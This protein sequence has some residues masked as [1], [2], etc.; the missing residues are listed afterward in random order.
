M[1][2]SQPR[3]PRLLLGLV[4]TLLLCTFFAPAPAFASVSGAIFTTDS[5]GTQVNGNIYSS[6]ADVYLN[7][8]PQNKQDPGLV[9]D[10]TYYFQV[11]D[12][13][14]A[15]LLSLDDIS[16][17]QVVVSGGRITGVPTTAPLAACVDGYHNLGTF[18][19]ANGEQ[20]V[21]LCNPNAS[22]CPT[23]FADTP[24]PG[25]VYKVWLTPVANYNNCSSAS[26]VTFGF[27]DSDSKTDTFKIKKPNAAYVTVCKFNDLN[28][29]GVQDSGEPLIPFWP[30]TATGVDTMSGPIGTVQAQTDATGCVS[31][32]VS[33]FTTAG[34]VVTMT[35][36]FLAG[37]WQ[38]TAPAVGSYSVPD[39][40][41]PADN[42][43]VTVAITTN[44]PGQPTNFETLTLTAGDNVAAPN[45]G[46]TCLDSTCGGNTIELTVTKD[47]NPM[48]TRT[49]AWGIT[50]SV[51]T[52]TVYSA[53]GGASGPANYTVS[54]THDSGTDSGWQV[55]GTINVSNPSLVDITGVTITDA[56]DN[57][58]TCSVNGGSAITVSAGMMAKIPYICTYSSL[59]VSGTNTATAAWNSGNSSAIGTASIN[60]AGAPF[61]A[62]DGSVTVTD[63]YGGTLGTVSYTDPSPTTYTYPHTF[64][65][66]AGTCTSHTNTATFT[67]NTTG[68][69]GTDSKTVA[70]CQGADLTVSKTATAT[71]NSKISKAVD[72]TRINTS[73]GSSATF[74]YT[75]TVTTS[76]WAVGGTIT[77]T[78]PND[79][80]DVSV[81]LADALSDTGG[82][83]SI[84]GGNTQTVLRSSSI[85]PTYSCNFAAVPGSSSGTNTATASWDST[86]A[87]TPDSSAQGTASFTFSA[88]TVTDSYKGTLGTVT[89]PPGSG[90]FNYSRTITAPAG[91]C[92]TYNNTASIQGGSSSGNV[93]VTVC[94]GVDL[95][96][97]KTATATYTPSITKTV[98]K[99]EI[100]TS[101]GSSAIFNY[102]VKVTTSGWT[103]SGNISVM[104]P[105]DWESITA[106]VADTLSDSG[107]ACAVNGGS[108]TVT[109]A[110]G[111]TASVPYT[112]S[113]AAVPGA[114]SGTNTATASWNSAAAFT[115]DASAQG[116]AGYTFSSFTVTDTYAGALGT[117]SIPPGSGT[118]AYSRTITAPTA[119]CQTYPNTASTSTGQSASQSVKVCG[120]SPLT[121]AKTAAATFASAIAKSV[122]KT[123]VQQ[124]GGNITFNY[125]VT[126]TESGWK[127][128]GN[129]MVTNPNNWESITAAVT[130]ALTD[131]GGV[132]SVIGGSGVAVAASSTATLPYS[133]SFA[134]RPTLTS[135]TNT[136]TATWNA[137]AAHTVANS[138][139]GTAGYAFNS[140]TITDNVQDS[141]NPTGCNATLGT[142]SVTTTTPN[143][144]PGCGVTSL[145][146][147]SWGAF[148]YSVADA[149]ASP[150]SCASYN[151]TA[152]ITGGSSSNQVTVTV[153]NTNTGALTMG[154]WKNSNGQSIITNHCGSTT[155]STSLWAYLSGFNP[156]KDDT[157]A[158][159][160]TCVK[161]A[162]YVSGIISGATCTS[163]TNTCNSML[164]A[165]ML[166]T[167]LDVYFSTPGLGGNQIGGYNGLG[168]K[169]PALGGVAIDLSHICSMIDSSSGSTCTGTY[170][171][172]RPEFGI[173]PPNLGTYVSNMLSYSDFLS[174]VNGSPV[175]SANTGAT[176]Y[177][178]VKGKQVIAKDAFD[179]INNQ[180][181][182]IAPSGITTPSF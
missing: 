112:C 10:G 150:G 91:T 63:T 32:S 28:G 154:F 37:S 141:A 102:T 40:V 86:A 152:Q 180:I 33:D 55:T 75:V 130:D 126:V 158:A 173:A 133:C 49:F 168:S 42:G 74:N 22:K 53:G 69:T 54:V 83:C 97:S 178:Q 132:C 99:T 16:C 56:V 82:A 100:D 71:Y 95:K 167:A 166:A 104:N 96:V 116:T 153:C 139:M 169:Q 62:V 137:T 39:G 114:S 122:N 134:A 120:A 9:P 65:D 15:V 58:G 89:I 162:T 165:Q 26:N 7:G 47:A 1:I 31:F 19:T 105:N 124:S 2:S 8:G 163:T 59:P 175:A 125:T 161:E 181:A 20:P 156:F 43:T 143:T 25:G 44:P 146:S 131:S 14:G 179:N 101:S 111:S 135:G 77:V 103:V 3:R 67:T 68:S 30:I 23:D 109:V 80:E 90:T 176:W 46:N 93:P 17:R 123:T 35:E 115:P 174:A 138:A 79:W 145:A 13:S 107:G 170:E 12:P 94:G 106:T 70:D 129:I 98:D 78:N 119:S 64:T 108:N 155:S 148:T 81:N 87:H 84:T 157:T 21:Q 128:T 57:N 60:F 76:G 142:L 72:N 41:I 61:K 140:L 88:L 4:T 45:F 118:F 159:Y 172:A 149:N 136:A 50:K 5:T 48:F 11:T 177:L 151:N 66:P 24:N 121:V 164:R 27:C 171:D 127:V 73:S 85:S 92:T 110:A 52:S 6:K 182:N 144:T 160:P 38:Q 36:G 113:F 51:D 34:G 29:N 117:I 147:P 18:N